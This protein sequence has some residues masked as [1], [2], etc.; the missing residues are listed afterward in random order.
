MRTSNFPS[1]VGTSQAFNGTYI[2]VYKH[3]NLLE[4]QWR[5]VS[6]AAG[7]PG[8]ALS[9]VTITNIDNTTSALQFNTTFNTG[10]GSN[11]YKK[12]QIPINYKSISV[13]DATPPGA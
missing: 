11:A 12:I 7:T 8:N 10:A 3:E 6:Y 9:T 4:I 13:T 2:D 1:S 5:T